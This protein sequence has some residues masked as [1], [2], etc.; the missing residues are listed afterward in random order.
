MMPNAHLVYQPKRLTRTLEANYGADNAESL[1]AEDIDAAL[2]DIAMRHG[3]R[4][5]L[6]DCEMRRSRGLQH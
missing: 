5:F 3:L 1:A 4:E 6:R 2:H